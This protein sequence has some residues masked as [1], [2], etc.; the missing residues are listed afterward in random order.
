[1]LGAAK[2]ARM[3]LT[4]AWATPGGNSMGLFGMA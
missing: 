2:K 4:N 1:V 3:S